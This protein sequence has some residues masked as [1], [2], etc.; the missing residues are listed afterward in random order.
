M[1]GRRRRRDGPMMAA[2]IALAVLYAAW[3]SFQGGLSGA[4][5][6]DG[7]IGVLLGLWTS[8]YPASHFLDLLLFHRSTLLRAG[9]RKSI[10]PWLL[11]NAVGL[12]IGLTIIIV[13][14]TRFTRRGP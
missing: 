6:V 3:L 7:V 1:E 12:A 13:G 14:M 11:I 10:V 4:D 9:D 2:L 5:R 8:S